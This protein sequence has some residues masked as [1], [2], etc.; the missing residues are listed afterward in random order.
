MNTKDKKEL[1]IKKKWVEKELSKN[2]KGEI[3]FEDLK[4]WIFESEDIGKDGHLKYQKKWSGYVTKI[5]GNDM[6]RFQK[7]ADIFTTAWNHFPH[8]VMDGLSPYEKAIAVY[9]SRDEMEAT[10]KNNTDPLRVTVGDKEMSVDE[11]VK[12]L[13]EMQE[14]QEPYKEWYK[15]LLT[16]YKD[17]SN[18]AKLPEDLY[19]VAEMFFERSCQLGYVDYEDIKLEWAMHEF[20]EWYTTHVM[21]SQMESG[22]V[23]DALFSLIKFI[24]VLAYESEESVA[25][26]VKKHVG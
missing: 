21:D 19:R 23:R 25:A 22:E 6:K 20:P 9:G 7:L 4:L 12:M 15:N 13:A 17:F 5:A 18:H 14:A 11:Y 16:A 10:K 26:N 24:D 1:E 8:K 3:S 2:F